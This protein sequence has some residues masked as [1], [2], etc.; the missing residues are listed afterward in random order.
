MAKATKQ[1]YE[2]FF[3]PDYL[4]LYVH[5]E[6]PAEVDAVER[7]LRVRK[8]ARILDLACGA[9]RH[10]V[11]LA[12]RGYSVTGVDLS[13]S[14][15]RQARKAATGLARR[16]TFVRADMRRLRYD[17]T[18]DAAISMFTS[19]GYFESPKED[20][21]VLD[22]IARALKPRGKFLME[23][24]NRDRLAAD[25]P[26]QGW[27]VRGDGTIVLQEDAFD[28]LRDRYETRQLVI[29]RKGTREY[30]A[31]VRAYTLAELKGMLDAHGLYLH[32]VLGAFDLSPYTP[33]SRRMLLYAVKGVSPESIRTMW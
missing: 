29:D 22:G 26:Q 19:F 2:K 13:E 16:P 9:G 21:R 12:R 3:G 20:A 17:E 23:R 7:I 33:R 11:E 28:A 4:S 8:G 18:F 24:F 14:M 31:S 1:W 30:A 10:S 6:T 32:R 5:E 15:L 27:R 25:L